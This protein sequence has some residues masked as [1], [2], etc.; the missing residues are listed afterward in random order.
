MTELKFSAKDRRDAE[1]ARAVTAGLADSVLRQAL[2]DRTLLE[3]IELWADINRCQIEESNSGV[4]KL[5]LSEN[6]SDC[7]WL[8]ISLED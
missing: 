7:V 3:V 1:A 2:R 4:Y 8:T 6:E 5:L